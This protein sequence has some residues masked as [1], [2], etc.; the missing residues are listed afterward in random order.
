MR[1]SSMKKLVIACS[2]WLVIWFVY[3]ALKD[4]KAHE[5]IQKTPETTK[6]TKII[7]GGPVC[8]KCGNPLKLKEI[9]IVKPQ[10][11]RLKYENTKK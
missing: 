6:E 1:K 7:K 9:Y 3:K 5:N 10:E 11:V 8:D 4:A 2:I